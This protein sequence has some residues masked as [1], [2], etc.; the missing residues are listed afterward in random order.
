MVFHGISILLTFEFLLFA[1]HRTDGI[2]CDPDL[3]W[4]VPQVRPR[5]IPERACFILPILKSCQSCPA[6][7]GVYNLQDLE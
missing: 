1:Y 5:K 7:D 4:S 3:L 2:G 6:K